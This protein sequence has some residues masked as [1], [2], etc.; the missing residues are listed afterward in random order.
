LASIVGALVAGGLRVVVNVEGV[1]VV[2]SN[3]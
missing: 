1:E 2:V 3:A